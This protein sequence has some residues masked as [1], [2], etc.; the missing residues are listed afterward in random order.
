MNKTLIYDLPFTDV[1][2]FI[3]IINVVKAFNTKDISDRRYLQ[4]KRKCLQTNYIVNMC[5]KFTLAV[6]ICH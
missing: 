6:D 5:N 3:D 4:E 2:F 1:A